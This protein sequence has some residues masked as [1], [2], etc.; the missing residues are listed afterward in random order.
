MRAGLDTD[1]WPLTRS[2][3]HLSGY[4]AYRLTAKASLAAQTVSATLGSAF[5]STPP[6]RE[7]DRTPFRIPEGSI[8]LVS[9]VGRQKPPTADLIHAKAIKQ[10]SDKKIIH[11]V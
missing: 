4:L 3:C 5:P 11:N 8:R 7:S 9:V 6:H 1:S 2:P 10:H